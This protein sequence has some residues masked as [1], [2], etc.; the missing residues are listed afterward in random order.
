M[1]V[2]A[3]GNT[4]GQAGVFETTAPEASRSGPASVQSGLSLTVSGVSSKAGQVETVRHVRLC[5]KRGIDIAVALAALIA[6]SPL[7]LVTTI[8]IAVTSRGGVLFW[9]AREGQ[10]GR[11]FFIFK[12]RSL[13]PCG[14]DLTPIGRFLRR[15]SIDELPQLYNVL[16]GEMSL[17]G[18]RPHVPDM[19]AAGRRYDE[20]VPYYR[21]RQVMRPGLTGWAQVNGLRGGTHDA[22]RARARIDHDLA[23]VQNFSLLLDFRIMLLTLLCE[24]PLGTGE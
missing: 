16:K 8:A 21:A 11:R 14:R 1:T 6:L 20:L 10:H 24:F 23:Y 18:P 7:L 4:P 17:V 13:S 15:T 12:F 22:G 2:F 19:M 9:Q 3:G 5:C